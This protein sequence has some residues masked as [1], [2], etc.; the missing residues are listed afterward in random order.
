M[1]FATAEIEPIVSTGGLGAASFGLVNALR[2]S[3]V[4]VTIVLPAYANYPLQD[5]TVMA[6]VV[7]GWAGPARARVGTHAAVG[8]V[9]LIEAPSLERPHP[10]V[11]PQTAQGWPDNDHRFFAWSA[12]VAALAHE[13]R[14]DVVHVNDW[15][16]A[17]TL[18]YLDDSFASV[19]SIH[20][21]A[22][23]G[24]G[25][26]GWLAALGSR[27]WAYGERGAVNALAGAIRLADAIVAVSPTYADEIRT[28]EG[29]LGLDGLL[30][31]R[32]DAVLGILNGIDTD[33][34]NP[35]TDPALVARFSADDLEARPQNQVALLEELGLDARPGPLVVSVSRFDAQKG[36][37]LIPAVSHLLAGTPARFAFLGSG[38]RSTEAA[39]ASVAAWNPG[40][41]AFRQGYDAALAHRLFA[42]GDFAIVPSRFEPCGLTQMQAMRYGSVPIVSNVGGLHDTVLDVDA[43]ARNGVGIVLREVSGAGIVD[44]VHRAARLF[45]K[46]ASYRKAQARGM[47]RDW[48]WDGPAARYHGLY[49]RV[50]SSR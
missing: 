45:S 48:S 21:L 34:W 7:P 19:L 15:H 31:E 22:H 41:I 2:R 16:A 49:E 29:G 5:E 17:A 44:G 42:A 28:F 6:L 26:R 12:G 27:S 36:I 46:P 14:P 18:S 4:E 30:S 47:A 25:D 39:L 11:D 35:A 33:D 43:D 8:A 32:G 3:G 9:A 23:Q 1:L 38:D 20:N 24:W 37:D 10:Y 40:R 13:L 50:M